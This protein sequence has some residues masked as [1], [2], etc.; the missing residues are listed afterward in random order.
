MNVRR[1][2][3]LAFIV[4]IL[5]GIAIT[6]SSD[7]APSVMPVPMAREPRAP[8][9]PRFDTIA[10]SYDPI[11]PLG[12]DAQIA[13]NAEQRAAALQLIGKAR[14]LSNVRRHPYLLKTTFTTSGTQSDGTWS[15]EDT[16]PA[17]MVYRWTAQGPGFSGTFLNLNSV[18]YSD[19]PTG[20]MPLRLAQVR[21]AMWSVYYPEIGPHAALR[22]AEGNAGGAGVRCVLVDRGIYGKN[23]EFPGGR[24]Y[25]DLEYCVDPKSGLLVSYS[26]VPGLY[27]RYDYSAAFHFHDSIVVPNA[28]TIFEAGKPVVEA[29]TLDIGDAPTATDR[30]FQSAGLN[31]LG[32]GQVTDPPERVGS[33]IPEDGSNV[34]VVVVATMR[35][36]NGHLSEAEVISSTNEN[37][38]A[39]AVA[40]LPQ[41]GIAQVNPEEQ[42]QP[43]VT[44]HSEEVIF[45]VEFFPRPPKPP[46]PANLRLP[47]NF[48]GNLGCQPQN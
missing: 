44:P 39:A 19:R 35:G 47:P 28:F 7:I 5:P 34:G 30:M 45:T 1:L 32:T 6:Q 38:N 33:F 11:E 29:R 24:S 42:Q 9:I 22:V 16:S 2:I 3:G 23:P 46:C 43:G 14:Q 17:P 31:L 10:A 41:S 26:P 21:N 36:A 20:E 4:A 40:H 18:M 25:A 37:L 27:V 48:N 15:I 8:V 12:S 13:D